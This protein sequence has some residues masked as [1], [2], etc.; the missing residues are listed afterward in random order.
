MARDLIAILG[1]ARS[2]KST[3][4]EKLALELGGTEVLYVATLEGR[5]EE[6][7]ERIRAHRAAR[8]AAWRTLEA[9]LRAGERVAGAAAGARVVVVDCL[10]LLA[11]NALLAAG[12]AAPPDLAD[13]AVSAELELLLGAADR[14]EAVWIVVSNE[15]GLGVVP[16]HPLGRVFRDALGRANQRLAAQA[17]QV[18]FMVAGLP[19]RLK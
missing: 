17:S 2:G 18:L 19:M 13:R 5:D 9:P 6:M 16:A 15:V 12:E 1:G 10:T 4:A 11:A 3:C 8:P 14:S 7:R